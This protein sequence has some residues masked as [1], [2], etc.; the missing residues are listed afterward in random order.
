MC[1]KLLRE[2]EFYLNVHVDRT[3]WEEH[4]TI[5]SSDIQNLC[6]IV[7][8][9]FDDIEPDIAYTV[10]VSIRCT[11]VRP[12]PDIYQDR[13]ACENVFDLVVRNAADI[14]DDYQERL[15]E[16]LRASNHSAFVI[17]KQWRKCV[18]NPDYKVC[19]DR[20]LREFSDLKRVQ[21]SDLCTKPRGKL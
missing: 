7:D 2:L 3:Y 21:A 14:L 11:L 8:N 20:L 4:N 6:D 13:F 19:K 15:T 17:Q 18:S 10:N 12:F 16:S 5:K 1:S 9:N